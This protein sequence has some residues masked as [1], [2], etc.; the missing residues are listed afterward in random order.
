VFR[1][2]GE[3]T[4]TPLDELYQRV[5][6]AMAAQ[7]DAN[8]LQAVALVAAIQAEESVLGEGFWQAIRVHLE[9]PGYARVIFQPYRIDAGGEGEKSQLALNNMIASDDEYV[10]F[11]EET[12]GDFGGA[13][14]FNLT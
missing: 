8:D 2:A 5:V 1:V 6:G 9:M 7:A 4:D 11:G 12:G 10:V 13:T 14:V 3:E